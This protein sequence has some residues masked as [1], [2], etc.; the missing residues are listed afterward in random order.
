MNNNFE[1]AREIV[2]KY[3]QEHLL[4]F[5]NK[6]EE[7]KKETLV[8]QILETDFELLNKLYNNINNEKKLECNIE[9]I[10][11]TDKSKLTNDERE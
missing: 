9:P 6:L 4:K 8:N 2:C 10:A 7:D 3:N 1:K 11:Y 5:Y